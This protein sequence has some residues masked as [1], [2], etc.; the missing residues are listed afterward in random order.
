MRTWNKLLV[1]IVA[2]FSLLGVAYAASSPITMLQRM[3]NNTL[4]ALSRANLRSGSSGNAQ[5]I[6]A[7]VSRYVIPSVDTHSMAASVVGRNYWNKA[8]SS[9]KKAFIS[10][11]IKLVVST[12]SAALSQ[13]NNDRVRFY[14]LRGRLSSVVTV[15]SLIVRRSGHTIS[16][17]YT[18]RSTGRGWKVIDFNIEGV[19]MVQ[20]YR[21][22][23]SS[24]LNSRGF[25]GLLQRLQTHNRNF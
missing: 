21:S 8:S 25:S 2:I 4:K 10:Q 1:A 23:F 7:I 22:Q 20:S 3:S 13:F 9:Q 6:H 11:F 17:N 19:S 14:P 16:V 5:K 18:V 12:Y 15:R 24:V